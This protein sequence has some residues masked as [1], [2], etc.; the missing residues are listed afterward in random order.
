MRHTNYVASIVSAFLVSGSLNA[1]SVFVDVEDVGP[2]NRVPDTR[3]TTQG[4]VFDW[5]GK[6][7]S[8]PAILPNNM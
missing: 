1:A 7:S 5:A 8:L 2:K 4:I 3:F 6:S